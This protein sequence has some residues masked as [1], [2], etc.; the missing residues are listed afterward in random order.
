[1]L[2][3]IVYY[4]VN[5]QLP[6][7]LCTLQNPLI[8]SIQ[9]SHPFTAFEKCNSSYY[10]YIIETERKLFDI[11]S[12]L[13]PFSWLDWHL[14]RIISETCRSDLTLIPHSTS[15]SSALTL[16]SHLFRY[17]A[18][19]FVTS[20]YFYFLHLSQYYRKYSRTCTSSFCRL[21]PSPHPHL[22]LLWR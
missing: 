16:T 4:A 19:C 22:R 15:Y 5:S 12:Q 11:C 20:N 7:L 14:Q 1:M 8:P 17:F 18:I 13:N 6:V 3:D 2:V 10:C 9:L 21:L